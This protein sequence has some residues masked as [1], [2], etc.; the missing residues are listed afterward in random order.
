MTLTLALISMVVAHF[1]GVARF[2]L[3]GYF[4]NTF[5]RPFPAMFP[6]EILD[7]LTNLLTLGLRIYGNIFAGELLLNLIA[8]LALPNNSLSSP[9]GFI[10]AI[11][12]ELIWQGFSVFIGAIQAFVFTT[13]TSVYISQMITKE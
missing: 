7:Q 1:A 5:L 4:K 8:S 9:I 11:P 10:V 12:L 3:K 13:L 2:G 6:L